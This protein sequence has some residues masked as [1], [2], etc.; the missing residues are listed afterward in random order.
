MLGNSKKRMFPDE[1][2]NYK[3]VALLGRGASSSVVLGSNKIDSNLY[4]LKLIP[5]EIY[6]RDKVHV[7]NELAILMTLSHPNIVKYQEH[8]TTDN[9]FV[10][11]T[12]YFD[13]ALPGK[14]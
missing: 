4:A 13:T 5:N 14:V 9:Y 12:E 7:E 1:I 6:E 3:Y 8:F 10:I 2:G 11:V